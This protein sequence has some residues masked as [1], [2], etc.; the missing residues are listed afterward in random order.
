MK[1]KYWVLTETDI[2]LSRRYSGFEGGQYIPGVSKP[3]GFWFG[4][5]GQWLVD[6]VGCE[7]YTID[8]YKKNPRSKKRF[9]F[10]RNQTGLDIYPRAA[11]EIFFTLRVVRA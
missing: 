2:D 10:S 1:S 6:G 7:T 8:F 3:K 4:L 11:G 9:E 5:G